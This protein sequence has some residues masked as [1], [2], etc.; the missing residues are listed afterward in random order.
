MQ[1]RAR[2]SAQPL[3]VMKH[4]VASLALVL[5]VVA[6]A[7]PPL[8]LYPAETPR[9]YRALHI[10]DRDWQSILA[11][12]PAEYGLEL[13]GAAHNYRQNWV[14]VWMKDPSLGPKPCGG[15]VL[16]FFRAKDGRWQEIKEG[17]TWGDCPQS[18]A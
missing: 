15:L 10:S 18:D 6:C 14:E 3:G 16:L 11:L 5:G 1:Q 2:R 9:L 7:V 4:L 12:I 17:A 8:T 13:Y